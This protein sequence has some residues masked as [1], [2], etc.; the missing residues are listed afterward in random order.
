M[1]KTPDTYNVRSELAI[2]YYLGC[3][4]TNNILG[5]LDPFD[6]QELMP[7]IRRVRHLGNQFGL[8][9]ERLINNFAGDVKLTELEKEKFTATV[10]GRLI[11]DATTLVVEPKKTKWGLVHPEGYRSVLFLNGPLQMEV[12]YLPNFNTFDNTVTMPIGKKMEDQFLS[13]Y[14]RHND[15]CIKWAQEDKN[16][17]PR[18]F[19]DNDDSFINVQQAIDYSVIRYKVSSYLDEKYIAIC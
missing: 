4:I 18:L 9:V 3:V 17:E 11:Y 2:F 14:F 16:F 13:N 1:I 12:K 15:D 6:K 19:T 5:K 7:A 8:A 10:I